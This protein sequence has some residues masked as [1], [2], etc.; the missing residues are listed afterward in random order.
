MALRKPLTSCLHINTGIKHKEA[1]Y[2]II[3]LDMW[4][5]TVCSARASGVSAG[6][7]GTDTCSFEHWYRH[8]WRVKVKYKAQKLEYQLHSV[9]PQ[10]HCAN[11]TSETETASR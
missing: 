8:C 1:S 4:H 6:T 7:V 9:E 3:T 2:D 5:D 10:N 11:V